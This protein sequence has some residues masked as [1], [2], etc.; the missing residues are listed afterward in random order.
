[1]I[2]EEKKA[3]LKKLWCAINGIIAIACAI[4]VYSGIS[5]MMASPLYGARVAAH[6]ALS[7]LVALGI[8]RAMAFV[9]YFITSKWIRWPSS[10]I[11]WLV[12]VIIAFMISGEVEN[13]VI[14][15]SIRVVQKDFHSAIEYIVKFETENGRYPETIPETYL[16]VNTIKF[17]G[18]HYGKDG[19]MIN[20]P[21]SS[22]DID[23]SN[24]FYESSRDQWFRVHNDILDA[25][26]NDDIRDEPDAPASIYKNAVKN[27]KQW[28]WNSNAR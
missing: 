20:C 15:K 13:Q 16:P 19:F 2:S 4:L 3:L 28:A 9:Q 26:T 6:M 11:K 22:I 1:M 14:K 24:V 10:I 8:N 17:F 12:A 18:Y 27:R 23:G 5:E 21:V 7:F 25:H